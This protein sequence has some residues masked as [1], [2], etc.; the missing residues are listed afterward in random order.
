MLLPMSVSP[1]ILVL[2]VSLDI[3]IVL[4][5]ILRKCLD[6]NVCK[7]EI[8]S[9]GRRKCFRAFKNKPTA[10]EMAHLRSVKGCTRLDCFPK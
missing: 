10:A 6:L 5:Y 7:F 3:L 4:P 1:A 2:H 9:S 8:A